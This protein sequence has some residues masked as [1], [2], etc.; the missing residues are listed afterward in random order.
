MGG[1]AMNSQRLED[2]NHGGSD[3]ASASR[4][5]CGALDAAA[6]AAAGQAIGLQ[7][8]AVYG[9]AVREPVPERLLKLLGKLDKA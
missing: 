5:Q 4:L 8:R 6:V 2:D 1:G 9:D 7:L 3:S